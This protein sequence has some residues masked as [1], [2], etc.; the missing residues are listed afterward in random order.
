M[1]NIRTKRDG[2]AFGYSGNDPEVDPDDY[3]SLEI[4]AGLH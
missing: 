3:E 1:D 4:F 2:K